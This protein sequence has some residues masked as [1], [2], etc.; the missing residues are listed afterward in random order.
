MPFN[1]KDYF[2]F[3]RGE[4]Q[5]IVVLLS[6]AVILGVLPW[7][8]PLFVKQEVIPFEPFEM[9]E[10]NNDSIAVAA[11]A[12]PMAKPLFYFDPNTISKDSLLLLGLPEKTAQTILNYRN[13]VKPFSTPADLKK[14]YNLDESIY[15]RL[16]PFVRIKKEVASITSVEK[17]NAELHEFDPNT[18]TREELLSL[19]IPQ[20]VVNTLINFR[21][22]GGRFYK[23]EDLKLVYGM[24][25]YDY[26]R[27]EAFIQISKMDS[28]SKQ[29]ATLVSKPQ[30]DEAKN[31]V[32]DINRA[33]PEEWQQLY[34][35][36]PGYARRITNFRD[37]L[38]G[39]HSIE[40][41][42]KT[43]GLPDSTFQNIKPHLR[44]S[45]IFR[46][47]KINLVTAE[48]LKKH[49]L[50]KWKE[51][52]TIISYRE[53]HGAFSGKESLLKIRGVKRERLE[54]LLPYLDFGAQ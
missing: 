31:V 45:P 10:I 14:I 13:K 43:Y 38:G 54:Q 33:T 7:I 49:P 25:D 12:E 5:G 18:A 1:W 3:S 9:E 19:G 15:F 16:A 20:K 2:Y 44:M 23:K 28:P 32:I 29:D 8:L 35:I 47:I 46:K 36:G 21:K 30:P 37:K 48:E 41:V 17:L 26:Q 52:N 34:G 6:L 51:A 53:Q 24:T 27:L 4:R 40:Q 11:A 42:A 50:L 39:F 22:K